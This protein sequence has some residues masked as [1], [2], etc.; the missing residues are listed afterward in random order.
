[1]KTKLIVCCDMAGGIGFQG[2]LPWEVRLKTDMEN[3]SELTRGGGKN[4]VLMGRA[5]WESLPPRHRPLKGRKNYVVS[6]SMGMDKVSENTY[7]YSDIRTAMRG[8][9]IDGVEEL[10]VIGGASIYAPFMDEPELSTSIDEVWVTVVHDV[11]E[12][13]R[14][15]PLDNIESWGEPNLEI[16]V[17]EHYKYTIK[18]YM[19]PCRSDPHKTKNEQNVDATVE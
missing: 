16:F 9:L 4:G 11:F 12:S 1:M 3:F 13:D 8:A 17:N 10:W 5:T 7:V 2:G 6:N 14:F 18:C 19:R 15:F